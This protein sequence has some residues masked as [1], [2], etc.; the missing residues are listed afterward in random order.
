MTDF[1]L[2]EIHSQPEVWQQVIELCEKE[3]RQ[4][5]TEW[6]RHERPVLTGSGS[7]FYLCLTAAAFYGQMTHRS[8]HF[9]QCP[10]L[11]D[12][13]IFGFGSFAEWE[14]NGNRRCRPLVR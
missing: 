13:K 3:E 14:V 9:P 12:R 2:N 4:K 5:I 11:R 1:T 6:M 10:V 7:S 8:M